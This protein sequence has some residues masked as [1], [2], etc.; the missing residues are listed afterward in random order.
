MT[1]H[2]EWIQLQCFGAGLLD[3]QVHA[4]LQRCDLPTGFK[5]TDS[6]DAWR[7]GLNLEALEYWF[8]YPREL[9]KL[10][11]L[12]TVWDPDPTRVAIFR[13]FGI[14]AMLLHKSSPPNGWLDRERDPH[15]AMLNLGM[16]EPRSL[17]G[18]EAVLV[19]GL[20]E[21]SKEEQMVSGIYE[22]PGFDHVL[23]T[24]EDNARLLAHW[25]EHCSRLGI[26]IVR[27]RPTSQELRCKGF[28]SLSLRDGADQRVTQYFH[29]NLHISALQFELAWR[30]DGKPGPIPVQTPSPVYVV[31]WESS[32]STPAQASICISL[33]N[34]QD[35]IIIA[36]ESVKAQSNPGIELII[37]DDASSDGSLEIAQQWLQHNHHGFSRILLLRHQD[38]AGLAAARN[39]GFLAA[40]SEW[41]FVLDA[42]NQMHPKAVEQCLNIAQYVPAE[43]AVIHP[44]IQ[45]I[46]EHGKLADGR[47][48]VGNLAWQR[49]QFREE[50][51]ID[52]MALIR[53]SAWAEV[54][55]YSNIV[56][57]WEDYDFWCKLIDMGFQGVLCPQV[58]ATYVSHGSSMI[59]SR[60]NQNVR[61]ISRT[62]QARHPWLDLPMAREDA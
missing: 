19:L 16:P 52:A 2:S 62:L 31:V 54:N 32:N 27:V 6:P 61:H 60:T 51:Y 42:D 39:T 4:W 7:I 38:N 15:D 22:W 28:E 49:L 44:L 50:N 36:L 11:Q 3:W 43:V 26:Q 40:S 23:I 55:G 17:A 48:L 37:V 56:D 18:P 46:A 24:N 58:L 8:G 9:E 34:Y 35:K 57:G 14:P 25:L 29:G 41:C 33:Y 13:A 20:I 1:T 59:N 21:A 45:R 12:D 10:S 47:D 30:R 5:L 53:K